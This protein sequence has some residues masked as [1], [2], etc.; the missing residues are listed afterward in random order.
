MG[1][2]DM[3]A[4]NDGTQN[5]ADFATKIASATGTNVCVNWKI[6]VYTFNS[7]FLEDRQFSVRDRPAGSAVTFVKNLEKRAVLRIL[8]LDVDVCLMTW[9]SMHA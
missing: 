5:T 2:I 9:L 7:K 8:G 6:H 3:L 1:P 4:E